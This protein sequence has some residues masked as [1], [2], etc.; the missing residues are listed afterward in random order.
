MKSDKVYALQ[1]VPGKG[2]GLVAVTKIIKG[3]R[4]FSESPLLRVPRS[5]NSKKRAGKSLAK[6]ISTLSDD[7]RQAFFSLYN[8]FEDEATPELGIVRTNALPLGSD[9]STGGVFVEASRVNHACLQNAQNSWNEGL[10]K[11]TIHSIRDIDEG[12]EITIMY[13]RDRT[14]RAARQL[15]L[16]RDF[17]FTCSCELCSLP[18]SRLGLSDARLNEIQRLDGS[19]GDGMQILASPLQALHDVCK[20]LRLCEEEGI[21]DA[22][23]SR[24]Y[25]DAFQI[26]IFNGDLARA[27]VFA[28][29]AAATRVVV[30]G[31]DSPTVR[32][33]RD[34][35]RDPT[36]HA[37]YCNTSRW[38]TLIHDVPSDLSAL[39]FAIW[40]WR[41]QQKTDH[42]C[43]QSSPQEAGEYA[44]LRDDA[45][46]PSFSALPE[47]N[48]LDLDF[49]ESNDDFSY[50]PRKHWCFLAEIVD[51]D[52]FL[53]LKF[54]VKDKAGQEVPVSFYTP[55]RGGELDPSYIQ[56]RSTLAILYGEQ[57]GFLDSTIGIR[58]E[59]PESL[60]VTSLLHLSS[61]LAPA[62]ADSD[63]SCLLHMMSCST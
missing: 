61:K 21:D 59:N 43:V 17:R 63:R 52:H 18:Q 37:S 22:T 53:R 25:Y 33:M 54:I 62:C 11:L 12:E 15:A 5:T 29:R 13:L 35:A 40:L 30:E 58:H 51:I 28:E 50:R 36:Q 7:E 41:E 3:T 34:L 39:G 42:A 31:D 16:Q 60:K 44:D 26:A 46:F 56:K 49:F 20:L 6:D 48:D 14:N 55:G 47:E 38:A 57:H 23:V 9:A 2:L 19:I 1:D 27:R 45:M 4:I 32:R 8:A 10:Q 24:A